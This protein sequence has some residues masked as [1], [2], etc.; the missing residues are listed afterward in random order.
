VKKILI[1]RFSSIGDIVLTT[2]V[3]RCLK[4]QLPDAEIH[5]LT[6]KQ[7]ASLLM[8]NPHI[9]KLWL[10]EGD[11]SSILPEMRKENF[12]FIIDLHK[13]LRSFYVRTSLRKPSASFDKLNLKKWLAV[14]FKANVLP[15][16]HIVDRYF[17][18][19][20]P[21]NIVNDG[22]GLDFF[23]PVEDEVDLSI[24]PDRFKKGFHAFVIGGKHTTKIFPWEKAAEVCRNSV[25]P[26]I[27][28]GGKEDEERGRKIVAACPEHAF[29]ACGKYSIL[30]SA[31]ILRQ[32]DRVV[33]NDTGLMH[34][35][36]ALG[37][38]IFSVWGNT[39]PAFGMYPYL[40]GK[41]GAVSRIFEVKD[42]SCRP[43]SKIGFDQCPKKHFRCMMDQDTKEMVRELNAQPS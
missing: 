18:A 26:F 33:T 35:A 12:D 34:I 2:P 7:N 32:A 23:I 13:N 22:K 38:D 28:L 8:Y 25:K 9:G 39:I 27:L 29:N 36:A 1:I 41:K 30:Q 16:L 42:L 17:H 11:F 14:N 4:M 40:E 15:D 20:K 10:Y 3:I 5:F 43:C 19:A 6:K 21:L 31:S 24:L 37:K